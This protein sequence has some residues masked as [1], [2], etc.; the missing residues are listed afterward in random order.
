MR[1]RQK[2]KY[3]TKKGLQT[4]EILQEKNLLSPALEGT[5][6][7]LNGC[8]NN[9][10]NHLNN[11]QIKGQIFKVGINKQNFKILEGF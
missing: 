8:Y 2:S 4:K 3:A 10:R 1:A 5:T 11:D 6:F 9:L 7:F